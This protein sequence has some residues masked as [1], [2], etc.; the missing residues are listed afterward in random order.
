MDRYIA[1]KPVRFDRRYAVG[2]E[3]PGAVIDPRN[4]KRLIDL[5]RIQA[6]TV[7][8]VIVDEDDS[9]DI[10]N[11]PDETV[12][13]PGDNENEQSET[14]NIPG[15]NDNGQSDKPENEPGTIC[16]VCGRVLGSKSAW[17][18]HMR[19]EHPDYDK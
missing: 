7:T 13:I 19:K 4:I 1:A 5:G 16:P 10:E 14:V 12:N 6:V 15:D 3:I 2:E 17:T 18:A 8:D 9:S 11:E